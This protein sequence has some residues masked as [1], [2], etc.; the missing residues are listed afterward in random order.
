M[1]EQDLLAPNKKQ[2][3]F[4]SKFIVSLESF[5]KTMKSTLNVKHFMTSCGH[6]FAEP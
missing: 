1:N 5:S 4:V 6:L 3:N 2:V